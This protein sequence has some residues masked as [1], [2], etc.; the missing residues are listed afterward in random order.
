MSAAPPNLRGDAIAD[1]G[2]LLGYV[3]DE[4]EARASTCVLLTISIVGDAWCCE[5]AREDEIVSRVSA[6]RLELALAGLAATVAD[7]GA[8][9]AGRRST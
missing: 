3:H 9:S 5:L 2:K 7:E 6:K 8:E 4:H 1:I